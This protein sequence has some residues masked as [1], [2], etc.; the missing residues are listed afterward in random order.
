MATL[1]SV[2]AK[3]IEQT[4]RPELAAMTESAVKTATLRAH[5]TDFFPRDKAEHLLAYTPINSPFYNIANISTVLTRMRS[6]KTIVGVDQ[7]SLAPCEEFEYRELDDL[8]DIDGNLRYSTYTLVGDTLRM[9]PSLPTGAAYI[10]YFQNPALGAAASAAPYNSW[11]ADMYED[12]LA[13]WAAV[14]IWTR[15]GFRQMAQDVLES[16]IKPFQNMLISSH[17]LGGV[18]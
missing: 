7:A 11:I 10:Y 12:Q 9:I 4:R 6:L 5:H 2:I 17:L 3:T 18:N 16:D 8:Y 14:I 13:L 15:T 1:E